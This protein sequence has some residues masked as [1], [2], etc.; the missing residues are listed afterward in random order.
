LECWGGEIYF[1]ECNEFSFTLDGNPCDLA[2]S[3]FWTVGPGWKIERA[4]LFAPCCHDL[5]LLQ[6]GYQRC[7]LCL[8]DVPKAS[9]FLETQENYAL[10]TV[11]PTLGLPSVLP[12]ESNPFY[13]AV[14]TVLGSAF[15]GK[16]VLPHFL[17]LVAAICP[18]SRYDIRE[19]ILVRDI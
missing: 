4:A 16:C 13:C 3:A 2:A 18:F 19:P 1:G 5:V 17:L 6:I 9:E 11:T 15:G 10:R 7:D 12:F 8:R 14:A